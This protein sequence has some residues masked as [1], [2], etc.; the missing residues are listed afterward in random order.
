M[1]LNLNELN[2]SYNGTKILNNINLTLNKGEILSLIGPNGSGKTTLLKCINKILKPDSGIIKLNELNIENFSLKE[3]AQN[4]GY[5]PQEDQSRFPVTVFDAILMG[6]KPYI[7]WKPSAEDLNIVKNIIQKLNIENISL[8]S[9]NELSGG[10]KQKVLLG[11]VLAQKP[12]IILLDEPTSNLDL[13]HQLETLNIIKKL[14]RENIS[15]IIAIHDLSLAERYSDKFVLLNKGK[16][17]AAGGR[18]IISEENIEKVYGVKISIK[19]HNG[20]KLIIPETPL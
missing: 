10:Q 17:F 6:R 12:E 15:V 18:E 7:R 13:K 5:V 2:F 8:K 1:K 20:R 16:V 3:M 9:I 19:N 11:R 14:S 4:L